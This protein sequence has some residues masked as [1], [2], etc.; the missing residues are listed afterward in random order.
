MDLP[1]TSRIVFSPM[2]PL[3]GKEYCLYSDNFYVSPTLADKLVD[4]ETDSVSTMR[5]TRKDVPAKIKDTKLKKGEIV[6][7]YQKSLSY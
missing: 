6:A 4:C 1:V 7:A 5:V 3:L 2:D